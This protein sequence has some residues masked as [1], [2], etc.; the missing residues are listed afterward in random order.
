MADLAPV[1][2]DATDLLDPPALNAPP[3]PSA[4]PATPVD[5]CT[6]AELS[7]DPGVPDAAA[8]ARALLARHPV[9][10]GLN[11]LAWEL[12]LRSGHELTPSR[13][14]LDTGEGGVHTDIPRLRA[15]HVAA[16][17]WSVSVPEV[18]TGDR[19]VSVTLEQVEF[20]HALIRAYPDALRLTLTADDM[21][22]ARRR[23]RVASLLAAGGGQCIDSS[24]GALRALFQLGVRR[25]A[26]AEGRNTPW[27]DAA[28]D[29]PRAGGLTLFGEE[30]IREMN[31]IGMLVDLSGS[32]AATMRR[33]I[34]ISKAPVVFSHSAARAL[35]DHP[36]NV[37][38]D[39][40]DRMAARGGVCMVTFEAEYVC[41]DGEGTATVR[42]VADHLDHVRAVAGP[43]H[44]GLGASYDT[45][46][47]GRPMGLE[48]TS[49]YPRLIAELVER[50]W[51][52]SDLAKLTWQNALR[53][54]RDTEF[55]ARATQHRRAPSTVTI[56]RLDG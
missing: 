44:I 8:R 27:A 34:A 46:G 37:P 11:G 25:M 35:T 22:E 51:P 5:P 12:R 52:E 24:L 50:G 42:D 40:L 36:A 33:A 26:L 1:L 3:A 2:L 20:V 41:P 38:D 53:V 28:A 32:S 13:F 55:T 16:Q 39:V 54:M 49:G 4:A 14:D 19:A 7:P 9:V 30:V 18:V 15:G 43:D 17:F 29:E 56:G 21:I 31:R 6:E 23:G 47:V 45:G 10:D 48:D